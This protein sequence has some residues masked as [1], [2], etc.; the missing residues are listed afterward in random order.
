MSWRGEG[1]DASPIARPVVVSVLPTAGYPVRI[2]ATEAE[3]AALAEAH[4]LVAVDAFV[5]DLDVRRWRKD[6]VRIRG[7]VKAHIVQQCIVS[8]EPVPAELDVEVDAVFLPE[9]SRLVRPLDDDGALIVDAEGPDIP[10]TF[11]GG[12]ID[13]GAVAEEFFEL[14][15]DP[16]P[17]APGADLGEIAGENDE[18][19]GE[20]ENPFAKLAGLR[21]KL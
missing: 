17:R 13:V 18:G 10:E 7:E 21:D 19:E 1:P 20:A 16:Y 8:L 3:R 15:I 6:G 4:D 12:E 9:G 5:A 11:A 14:A 2:E